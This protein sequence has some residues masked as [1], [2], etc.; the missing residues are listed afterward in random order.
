[1]LSAMEQLVLRR[2]KL[3]VAAANRA[4]SEAPAASADTGQ[5][6]PTIGHL[7]HPA[8]RYEGGGLNGGEAAGGQAVDQLDFDGGGDW[9]GF[10]LQPV[11]GAYLHQLDLP[12][13][14]VVHGA[15]PSPEHAV[16]RQACH[17]FHCCS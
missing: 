16:T 14:A 17:R 1:M 5:H 7:G 13:S 4:I 3:S 8:G 11:P 6:F 12:G 2:E 15:T 9:P 10:V